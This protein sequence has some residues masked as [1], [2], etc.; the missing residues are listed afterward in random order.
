MVTRHLLDN[1]TNLGLHPGLAEDEKA[2]V[3]LVN[4]VLLVLVLTNTSSLGVLLLAAPTL[5]WLTGPCFL[6]YGVAF[7]LNSIRAYAGAGFL[8]ATT[9]PVIIFLSHIGLVGENEPAIVAITIYSVCL[10]V[11]PWILLGTTQPVTLAGA[12]ATC[13]TCVLLVPL[14][15]KGYLSSTMMARISVPRFLSG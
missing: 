12:V 9:Q 10:L 11:L 7:W 4:Q 6:A 3:R 15:P 2:N 5:A 14:W 8:G 1:A 13:L